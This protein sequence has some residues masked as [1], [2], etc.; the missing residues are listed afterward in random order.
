V[1]GR[2]VGE[3]KAGKEEVGGKGREERR[4]GAEVGEGSRRENQRGEGGER[5]W[6]EQRGE[7]GMTKSDVGGDE[8]GGR[9][10]GA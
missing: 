5:K 4:R 1:W 3:R 9:V 2:G 8:S 7:G 10:K 6:H